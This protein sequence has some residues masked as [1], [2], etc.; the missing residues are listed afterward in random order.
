MGPP[1]GELVK[2][3]ETVLGALREGEKTLR[4]GAVAGDI[5]KR[6]SDHLAAAGYSPLVH[7]AGHVVGDKE[8]E[9]PDF[10]E[11]APGVLLAGM[12]VT[13]EPG[14]YREGQNGI[15]VENNYLIT[16]DGYEPLFEYPEDINHFTIDC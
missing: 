3:Y 9:E 7:H 2:T 10:T 12:V 8:L 14:V 11:N 4:P 15:R 16:Q 5:Y 13:L 6:V 1:S